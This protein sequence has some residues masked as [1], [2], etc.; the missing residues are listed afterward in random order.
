MLRRP[1]QALAMAGTVLVFLGLSV[2]WLGSM[3][4]GAVA[5]HWFVDWVWPG[6]D[7]RQGFSLAWWGI[8]YAGLTSG[9]ANKHNLI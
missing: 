5:V 2:A 8:T 9:F 6:D 7:A 1:F 3:I 4:A